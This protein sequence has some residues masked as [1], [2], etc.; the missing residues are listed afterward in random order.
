MSHF[1]IVKS[2]NEARRRRRRALLNKTAVAVIL[3]QQEARYVDLRGQYCQLNDKTPAVS[4]FFGDGDLKKDF[5]LS[6]E[7]V[8]ALVEA[9]VDEHIH[10]W[11]RELEVAVFLYWLASATSYRVVSEAFDVPLS[12]VHMIVHRV[13]KGILQI[14]TKAVCFPS[15]A[16]LEV[17][18][19]G[20]A[21]LAGSPALN[22][23]AGSIDCIHI[24]IKPPGEYKEDYYNRKL[25][26]SIQL[27]AICDHKGRFLNAFVGLPG[28]VHDAR[29]LR[30]S[31][32]YV[33]Q[34]YPPPGWCI[35][36]DG[37][38]PCLATPICLMTPFR[39]PVQGPVQARY[40]KHLSK[41]RCVV[42]RAFG[43]M[44]TRWRSIFLKALEVKKT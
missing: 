30:W 2:N 41:A 17:I 43:M 27:Q 4:L 24:R 1:S 22:R 11:G 23:V 29:V 18:G 32:V 10:G 6:R 5:R 44:K 13:A 35:I 16:E 38:Y 42:E 8:N 28:S 34:L 19:A 7:S 36:G 14:Y 12:T 25:F 21:Q 3:Q 33:Q 31:S 20:F 37:G 9:L 26:H 40:N 39:E 15:E